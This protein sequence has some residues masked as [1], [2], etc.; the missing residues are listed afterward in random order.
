MFWRWKIFPSRKEIFPFNR[1]SQ[2]SS[3]VI[4]LLLWWWFSYQPDVYY[5][6]FVSVCVCLYCIEINIY[7]WEWWCFAVHYFLLLFGIF[8]MIKLFWSK[9][10]RSFDFYARKKLFIKN[11]KL[12][13][14]FFAKRKIII[15]KAYVY[16]SNFCSFVDDW[17][18]CLWDSVGIAR[19]VHSWL[20][21][22]SV[23]RWR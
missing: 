16:A 11:E 15:M 19:P 4:F 12:F 10:I 9:L 18:W 17:S 23:P 13:L 3:S 7:D 20:P 6:A 2:K 14:L 8:E 22:K 1:V 21:F 5:V